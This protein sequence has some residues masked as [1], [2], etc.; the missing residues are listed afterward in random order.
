MSSESVIQELHDLVE[1]LASVDTGALGADELQSLAVALECERARLAVAAAAVTVAWEQSGVWQVDGSLRPQLALGRDARRDHRVLRRELRRARLLARMPHTRAAVLAG[2]LSMDHVD[3]FVHHATAARFELFLACEHALVEQCAGC[4]L[5]DDARRVV[6]YWAAWADDQLE[7]QHEPSRPSTLYASRAE[8]TGEWFL[9]GHLSAL[10]GEIVTR[11]LERL[12]RQLQLEDRHHG[13]VRT[14]AQRRAAA[15]VRMASRSVNATGITARPLF[16]VVVGDETARRLCQLASGTVVHPDDLTGHLDTALMEVFLFD[17][18]HTVLAV[19]RQRT[20]RGALRRA[21]QVRDRR[22]QHDSVCPTPADT[23]DIDHRTPAARGGPTS[24]FNG[25]VGC[26]PHN[27]LAHLRDHPDPIP[28]R[29][30]TTLDT[31]R[32]RL[33]WHYLRNEPPDPDEAE[34]GQPGEP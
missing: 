22:C 27:R 30:V 31:I 28:E 24:Q 5:F 14:P 15:L 32:C 17:G 12:A 20:F 16:Q 26:V 8:L 13:V 25:R 2:R 29:P 9:D 6:Q 3:L 18:P 21:I 4:S 11:E 23:S 1:R 10:D 7:L 33:R 34:P 19:S